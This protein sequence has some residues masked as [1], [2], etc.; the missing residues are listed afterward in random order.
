MIQAQRSYLPRLIV[1]GL[2]ADPARWLLKARSPL[3]KWATYTNLL[4]WPDDHP[5]VRTYKALIHEDDDFTRITDAQLDD[6]TWPG[7]GPFPGS[8]NYGAYY[9]GTVWQLPLLADLQVK[10]G[11][12]YADMAYETLSRSIS[13]DG[14][15]DLAGKGLPL[16]RANAVVCGA[17]LDMGF[18][19][20]EL[21][22]TLYWLCNQQRY[23]GGWSDFYELNTEDAPSSF[24]TTGTVLYAL[25][26]RQNPGDTTIANRAKKGA[27]YLMANLFGDYL[28][29]FPR[30]SKAW[31]KLSWPQYNFDILSIGRAL[32]M[33]GYRREELQNITKAIAA[34]QTHRGYWRQEVLI[35]APTH[36]MPVTTSRASRWLTFKATGYFIGLYTGG[37][38][39]LSE[40][41]DN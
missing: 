18:P 28:E 11:A 7:I 40:L 8:G 29:R 25:R 17:F 35:I 3:V 14:F 22:N 13:T 24:K 31:G 23:D 1:D 36:I 20:E 2:K 41:F 15:F 27:A 4:E 37:N 5:E 26:S 38:R 10:A 30:S 34:K 16:I 9:T 12:Q 6:G 32:Q 21:K 33:S 39:G 19:R